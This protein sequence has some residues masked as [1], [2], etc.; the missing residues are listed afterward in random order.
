MLI[1]K[2]RAENERLRGVIKVAERFVWQLYRES[3]KLP[4]DPAKQVWLDLKH[5]LEG[6]E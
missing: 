5:A 1:A 6:G 4:E 3:G 2:L